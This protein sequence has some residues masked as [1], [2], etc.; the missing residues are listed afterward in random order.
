MSGTFS[1]SEIASRDVALRAGK[2]IRVLNSR[3]VTAGLGLI[4][5]RIAREFEA[6]KSYSEVLSCIDSWIKKTEI[7]V[8]VPTLKY[9]IRSGRVSHFKSFIARMLDLKPII[10]VDKDGKAYLFSKSFTM[11]GSM[12]KVVHDISR[13]LKH[14]KLWEYAITHADNPAG[15][16]WYQTKME[17]L[18]GKRPVF[19]DHAS[20]ALVANTGP[21]VVC[22]S[23]VLE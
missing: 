15:A 10:S 11:K 9:I 6:G 13:L 3:S 21:G 17:Q 7:R 12:E 4:V 18:T 8:T 16:E 19:V 22:V 14:N 20:P 23:L 2:E 1:N 5:L